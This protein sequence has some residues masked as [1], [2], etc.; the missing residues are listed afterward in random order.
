MET[1]TL[2]DIEFQLKIRKIFQFHHKL[3][4]YDVVILHCIWDVVCFD[5]I[6]KPIILYEHLAG[7]PSTFMFKEIMKRIGLINPIRRMICE[8]DRVK[9]I[10]YVRKLYDMVDLVLC[11]S[12]FI[13]SQLKKYYGVE[14]EVLY[15]PV[16]LSTFKPAKNPKRT[17]FLSA[18]RIN[19]QKRVELQIEAFEGLNEKLVIVGGPGGKRNDDLIQLVKEYDNIEFLGSVSQ[20]ELVSLYANAKAT[21]QTGYYEDFGL[22]PVE[23]FACGTPAIVVD[24][25]GFKET[26]HNSQLGIRVKKPYVKNLRE[27]ILSFDSSSY[28]PKVLR[29]EAEK[30]SL[31][32]FKKKLEEYIELAI[33]NYNR[34][35][36]S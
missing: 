33:E 21:I 35:R 23:G 16:D 36:C 17:Y 31:K 28:D 6:D 8:R 29:R 9:V 3:H 24:E 13:R 20:E 14:S 12:K 15:P 22:V 32:R 26:V 4:E 2:K 19:W 10:E 18:Q 1:Y 11:N 27:V 30:Y 25:G 7:R 5:K 34:R